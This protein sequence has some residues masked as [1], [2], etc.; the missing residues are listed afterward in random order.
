MVRVNLNCGT[1]GTMSAGVL[2]AQAEYWQ[3]NGAAIRE[4]VAGG[5]ALARVK[6]LAARIWPAPGYRLGVSYCTTTLSC[7]LASMWDG[8][9]GSVPC[10]TTTEE[11]HGGIGAFEVRRNMQVIRFA[12]ADAEAGVELA[13]QHRP[14]VAWISQITYM[15]GFAPDVARLYQGIKESNPECLVILD[16]AQVVGAMPVAFECADVV[17]ASGHKWLSGPRGMGFI[18]VRDGVADRLPALL[19]H[20]R[21]ADPGTGLAAF[22]PTGG[23]NWSGFAGL[24]VALQEF[25]ELGPELVAGKCLQLRAVLAEGLVGEPEVR[26][27][28]RVH[29]ADHPGILILEPTGRVDLGVVFSRLNEMG[30]YVRFIEEARVLRVSV[31]YRLDQGEVLQLVP[32]LVKALQ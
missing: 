10:L 16:C 11:H 9:G 29:L 18:W 28:F 27:R 15:R 21:P 2:S 7:L 1:F 22:E 6:G 3:L 32:A 17:V 4:Y 5:E 12:P 13:R 20:N 19:T 8:R 25:L 26:D 31:H 24:A 14:K 30:V 23:L